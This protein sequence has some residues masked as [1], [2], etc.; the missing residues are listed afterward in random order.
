M[1][2]KYLVKIAGMRSEFTANNF[3]ADNK[4]KVNISGIGDKFNTLSKSRMM[5]AKPVAKAGGVLAAVRAA[6][7]LR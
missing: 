6:K 1:A 5:G 4:P 3:L 2:N 7:G